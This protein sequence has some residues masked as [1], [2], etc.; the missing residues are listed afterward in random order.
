MP[1]ASSRSSRKRNNIRCVT[2]GKDATTASLPC[3]YV[4]ATVVLALRISWYHCPLYI[5]NPTRKSSFFSVLS[6]QAEQQQQQ[7]QQQY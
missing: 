5:H 4:W 2:P 6:S 7:Q 3:T 1:A